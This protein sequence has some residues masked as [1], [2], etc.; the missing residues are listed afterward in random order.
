M[1]L[2]HP[3]K[4][5]QIEV[6]LIGPGKGECAL[7][8]LGNNNWIVID[9]CI[10]SATH[11]PAA[12]SYFQEIGVV[13]SEAVKLIIATHWH[14][15][16]IMGLHETLLQCSKAAFCASSAMTSEEFIAYVSTY[17]KRN[18]IKAGPG[19]QEIFDV[20]R[21]LASEKDPIT[22]I[23][24]APN[25]RIFSLPKDKSGHGEECIVWTVSPS[26]KQ[27]DR[28]FT[29]LTR[30]MPNVKETKHRATPQDPNHLTV[31][32]I[33]EI[34]SISILL[35]GDLEE[36]EDDETG[37]SVIVDSKERPQGKASIFKI[38]HHGSKNAHNHDLWEKMLVDSPFA[39]LTPYNR[40][41]KKLPSKDDVT[42]ISG[43]TDKSYSTA[44]HDVARTKKSR[45]RAVEKTIE[46]T[47]GKLRQIEPR[48]GVIR[49]R[50]GGS[51]Y[52]NNW[53]IEL[54]DDA[55]LL[56]ELH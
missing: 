32:S 34:G 53:S 41:R 37:W 56:K 25:R 35:G 50:N 15:D 49:L 10:N 12:L 54:F 11:K 30:L 28:F 1:K 38:P 55:C 36:T 39:I 24:A 52:K 16:H 20:Q 3:P 51:T 21:L 4:A 46:G 23:K 13:P 6:T 22:M 5:D 48:T 31:V 8:H 40:G 44:K 2:N 45:P 47:V 7:V 26:D 33:V 42:R 29:E 27:T 17:E 19:V 43:Y 18:M 9:S 14:D